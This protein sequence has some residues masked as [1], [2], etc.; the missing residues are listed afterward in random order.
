[1]NLGNETVELTEQGM[2]LLADWAEVMLDKGYA[3]DTPGNINDAASFLVANGHSEF[4][5]DQTI[6]MLGFL[7]DIWDTICEF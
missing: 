1:M 7:I 3:P 6:L 4:S 2:E 5:V